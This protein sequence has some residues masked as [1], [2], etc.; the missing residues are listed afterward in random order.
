MLVIVDCE[1]K[2][3]KRPARGPEAPEARGV[4]PGGNK[5][6]VTVPVTVCLNNIQP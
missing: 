3:L 4:G 1:L 2:E 6:H 5:L